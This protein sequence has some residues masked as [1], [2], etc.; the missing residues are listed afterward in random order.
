MDGV[1]G[2]INGCIVTRIH[3]ATH[4]VSLARCQEGERVQREE[5]THRETKRDVHHYTKHDTKDEATGGNLVCCSC[6]LTGGE[7]EIEGG[8]EA[9]CGVWCCGMLRCVVLWDVDRVLWRTD[10]VL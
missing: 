2:L 7:G 4:A 6:P 1:D 3:Y 5:N 10:F 8:R 9:G